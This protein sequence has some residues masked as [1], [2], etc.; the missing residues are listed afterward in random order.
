MMNSKGALLHQQIMG[1][2]HQYFTSCQTRRGVTLEQA[3]VDKE[4]GVRRVRGWLGS[5]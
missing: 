5:V 1:Y 2:P 4:G 3:S